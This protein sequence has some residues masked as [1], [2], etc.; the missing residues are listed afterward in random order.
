MVCVQQLVLSGGSVNKYV[1]VFIPATFVGQ[2]VLSHD[3]GRVGICLLPE[4]KNKPFLFV[5][6][7]DLWLL[8]GVI[9]LP[10]I[11]INSLYI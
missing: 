3:P 1:S 6:L 10:C 8:L 11:P 9:I 2:L 5:L 7:C 4:K